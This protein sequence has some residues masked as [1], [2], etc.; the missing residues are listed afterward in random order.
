MQCY[1]MACSLYDPLS[2]HVF[3]SWQTDSDSDFICQVAL[4]L[5]RLVI[6]IMEEEL[7]QIKM[8]WVILIAHVLKGSHGRN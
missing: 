8:M 3:Y 2:V 4:P 1:M 6:E 5:L 7:S